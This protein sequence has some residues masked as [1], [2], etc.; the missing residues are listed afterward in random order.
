MNGT[1]VAGVK[2]LNQQL[3]Q[4]AERSS[5]VLSVQRGRYVYNLTFPMG[6]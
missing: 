6:V 2:E 1:E 3:T 5:F 4:A